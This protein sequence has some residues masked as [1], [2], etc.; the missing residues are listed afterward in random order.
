MKGKRKHIGAMIAMPLVVMLSIAAY[1]LTRPTQD[2]FAA[3]AIT[4]PP[5]TSITYGVQAFLWWGGEHVGLQ[6]DQIRIMNFSH[7]KQ[8]F[9]WV[10]IEP[11]RGQWDFSR[12]DALLEEIER[13]D[14]KLVARL[15]SAPEWAIQNALAATD[16]PFIDAPPDN[17]EDWAN[18]CGTVAERYRGRI[19]AYQIWNEPNLSREWGNQAPDPVG[20][21][22]LLKA[23]SEAIRAADPQAIIISAG[24]APTGNHNDLANRDDIYLDQLYQYG[25]QQYIDVVGVHAPGYAPPWYGPDDAER[26]G[27][28]RWATFRRIEDLRKIMIQNGDAARQM[29]I[30]EMGWTTD[31][32]HPEYAWFAVSEEQQ[33]EYLVAAYRYAAEHWRP[34]V[35]L[36]VTIYFA[37]PAWTPDNEEWWWAIDPSVGRPAYGD[38][39]NMEKY[40]G[41]RFIPERAPDSPEALG[42]V[43]RTPCD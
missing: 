4:N 3:D 41:D 32:I 10:N 12:A 25:F 15:G 5:F 35:G 29:A 42:L 14:L 40:C 18:F 16:E 31:Q 2:P 37:D 28:G 11:R 24:L 20:Y 38:L 33:S 23:C 6:L 1:G 43:T 21:V 17:L 19:S 9:D 26:D 36:M 13:R 27:Q 7:V 8:T 39:A 34:W 22:A 30:L